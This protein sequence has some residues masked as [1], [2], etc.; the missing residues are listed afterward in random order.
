MF[1]PLRSGVGSRG[2][3]R[4]DFGFILRRIPSV[5][6]YT[7]TVTDFQNFWLEVGTLLVEQRDISAHEVASQTKRFARHRGDDQ[8]ELLSRGFCLTVK[9][10]HGNVELLEPMDTVH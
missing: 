7:M 8:P 3:S 9:D 4:M 10:E 2:T 6:T 1:I 5:R